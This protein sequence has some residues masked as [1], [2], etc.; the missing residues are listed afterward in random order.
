MTRLNT[1]IRFEI[2]AEIAERINKHCSLLGRKRGDLSRSLMLLGL[3]DLE[4]HLID[5]YFPSFEPLPNTV[6]LKIKYGEKTKR[7]V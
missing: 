1:E 7:K 2:T 4:K 6:L 3:E 5:G